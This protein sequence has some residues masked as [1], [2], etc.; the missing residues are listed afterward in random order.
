MAINTQKFL[1]SAKGGALAK[2]SGKS[3]FVSVSKKTVD[4]I[5]VI[6]VNVIE[7]DKIMKGSV[8]AKKAELD[9][10]KKEASESRK[11]SIEKDLETKPN[12]EKK[13]AK[14]PKVPGVGILGWIKNFIGNIL[15]GYFAVRLV[16]HLPKILPVL[17]FLGKAADFVIDIGGKLLDGLAT[18]VDWGYK[19]YDATRGFVKNI[20]GDNGVKQFDKLAGLLNTVLNLAVIAAMIGVGGGGGGP[21]GRGGQRP[22]PGAGGR[23]RVTTSG[24]RSAGR[25][26]IRNP[27]R[28]R[29]TVTTGRGGVGSGARVTGA[30]S[31]LGEQGLKKAAGRFIRPVVKEFLSLVL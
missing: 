13:D 19:A 7:I 9:R 11:E 30:A 21:G 22:R 31:E 1:P 5:G 23:P 25:P 2:I 20:F 26:D 29:P 6:K 17:K 10:K 3:T 14:M 12:A 18:F 8:V 15:L 16:D 4:D 28:Q 27:L 24:G